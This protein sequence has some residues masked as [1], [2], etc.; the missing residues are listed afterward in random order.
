MDNKK[1][2]LQKKNFILIGIGLL[3]VVIG[4]LLMSGSG[5]TQTTFDPAIFSVQRIKVAP[6]A[7]LIGFLTIIFG[8]LYAPS[9]TNE[10]E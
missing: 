6:V 7:C 5:T 2:A 3:V 4:F 8:I 10:K 9:I 1:L